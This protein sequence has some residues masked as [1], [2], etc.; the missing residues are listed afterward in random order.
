MCQGV[1]P[2][3]IC[4]SE[5]SAVTDRDHRGPGERSQG[6]QENVPPLG[7]V[8]KGG[9]KWFLPL[10]FLTPSQFGASLLPIVHLGK[11]TSPKNCALYL[12]V[13]GQIWPKRATSSQRLELKA[14]S[15]A[16]IWITDLLGQ[17]PMG[18]LGH[19]RTLARPSGSWGGTSW[20][21]DQGWLD[22]WRKLFNYQ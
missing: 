11:I 19:S 22:F 1:G 13:E 7:T 6:P 3:F 15:S 12:L 9:S 5:I 4:T 8:E 10:P 2:S 18:P 14:E 21:Q 17:S 20:A 16:S